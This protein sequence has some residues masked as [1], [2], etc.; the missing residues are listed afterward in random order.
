MVIIDGSLLQKVIC[1]FTRVLRLLIELAISVCPPDLI[2]AVT[3]ITIKTR[4]MR[5][6]MPISEMH[7]ASLFQLG[8]T[9]TSS[10]KI[11]HPLFWCRNTNFNRNE[12]VLSIPIH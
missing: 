9:P 7:I 2:N 11:W 3:S 12:M 5:L 6:N 1:T 10:P 8:A 4:M